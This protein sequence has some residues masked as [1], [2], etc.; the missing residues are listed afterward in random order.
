M[1]R[2]QFRQ[3]FGG[4]PELADAAGALRARQLVEEIRVD[5]AR[6]IGGEEAT[7]QQRV[8]QF[9]RIAR[10][11]SLLVADALDGGRVESAQVVR[12]RGLGRAAGVDGPRTAWR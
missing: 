9:I 6:F 8:V 3:A 12:G 7:G 11:G 10:I 1:N 4:D 2:Q 5:L